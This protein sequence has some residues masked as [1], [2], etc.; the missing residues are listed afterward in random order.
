MA[1][2]LTEINRLALKSEFEDKEIYQTMRSLQ[3][4]FLHTYKMGGAL[5]VIEAKI[6]G[7]YFYVI[8]NQELGLMGFVGRGSKDKNKICFTIK[9]K[10]RVK[11]AANE[12]FELT[13]ELLNKIGIFAKCKAMNDFILFMAG[14]TGYEFTGYI[15]S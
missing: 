14:K 1:Q 5:R 8:E 10:S 13:D 6:K 4:L 7:N 2:K 15:R 9:D 3:F 12:G 11:W